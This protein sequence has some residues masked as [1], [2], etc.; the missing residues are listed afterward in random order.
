MKLV[1]LNTWGKCGPY[2]ERW[3]YF[4]RKLGN[5]SPDILCLQE[6]MDDELTKLLRNNLGFN[7]LASAYGAGLLMLSRFP[8]DKSNVL[9]YQHRSPSEINYERKAIITKMKIDK[10]DL[11]IANTHLA[12]REEDRPTR[13]GQVKELL[14]TVKKMGF[15]SI[16]CGDLNDIPESSPLEA[17]MTADYENLI[18]RFHPDIITWDNN[19][20][21]IQTHSVRFPDRQIDYILIHESVSKIL[22]ADSCRRCFD[23]PNE[24]LIYPSDHYGVTAEFSNR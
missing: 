14:E 4:L 11:V 23:Q 19:N 1:T 16:I 24:K 12:W 2:K 15:P 3:E 7:H 10:K 8:I 20:P 17:T 6:V 21:F 9:D 18:Q 13:N 22:N 5:L